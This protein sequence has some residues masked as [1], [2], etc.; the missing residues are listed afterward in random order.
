MTLRTN[1]PLLRTTAALAP[2][3]LRMGGKRPRYV[4]YAVV[5]K[6][7]PDI[8]KV[9]RTYNWRNRRDVY[10]KWNLRSNNDGIAEERL[11][12]VNEEYVDLD[13][14]EAACLRGMPSEP[15]FGKEWFREELE[16]ACRVI[17]QVMCAGGLTYE[18]VF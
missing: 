12:I 4:I 5:V 17:D 2:K 9:G 11:F 6:D 8:V 18:S 7:H 13:K 14:L 15:V 1:P 10:A 3:P 16:T